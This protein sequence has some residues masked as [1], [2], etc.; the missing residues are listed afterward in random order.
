MTTNPKTDMKI[1]YKIYGDEKLL[2]TMP[3]IKGKYTV[4]V[5]TVGKYITNTE[6]IAEYKKRDLIPADLKAILSVE[7]QHD[8]IATIWDGNCYAA[9]SQWGGD[10]RSVFVDSYDGVWNDDWWFAGLRKTGTQTSDTQHLPLDTQN[11]EVLINS[12]VYVPVE[13]FKREDIQ[14]LLGSND[15]E[16]LWIPF[17]EYGV[18][19]MTLKNL[20]YLLSTTLS[21][22]VKEME[23]LKKETKSEFDTGSEFSY[24]RLIRENG[25]N[26]GISAAVE[27]VKK[28]GV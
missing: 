11:L 22:L 1:P 20:D 12:V 7:E 28:M 14:V 15:R 10:G 18:R 2:E 6:L 8:Y 21:T 27:M 26:A 9:F 13:W 17:G 19:P 24:P 25:F 5:F 16:F 3:V 23:G 4:E